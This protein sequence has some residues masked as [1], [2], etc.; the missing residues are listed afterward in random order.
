VTGHDATKRSAHAR[1][2]DRKAGDPARR[3]QRAPLASL[4]QATVLAAAF[5]IIG[6][7][8]AVLLG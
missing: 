7:M 1:V 5:G 6:T 3:R 2:T 8:G 4:G